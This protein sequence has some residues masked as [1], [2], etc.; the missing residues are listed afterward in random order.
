MSNK[1]RLPAKKLHLTIPSRPG[2]K[3]R[4]SAQTSPSASGKARRQFVAPP[5]TLFKPFLPAK[6]VEQEPLAAVSDTPF[7]PFL[8]AKP[9]EQ[10]STRKEEAIVLKAIAEEDTLVDYAP[11]DISKKRTLSQITEIS[12]PKTPRGDS[13]S[14]E[15]DQQFSE[16]VGAYAAWLV[17][18][19]ARSPQKKD[20]EEKRLYIQEATRTVHLKKRNIN[21]F[22]PFRKEFSAFQTFT[23]KQLVFFLL[24][25]IAWLVGLYFFHLG[26]LTLLVGIVTGTYTVCLFI[27]TLLAARSFWGQVEEHFDNELVDALKSVPWPKYT[28]LC[29]LY[30]EAAIVPQFVEAMKKLDYPE[31]QLQILLLTEEQ[32]RETRKAIRAFHLPRQFEIVVVPNGQPRT[33]PRACNYG[34]LK[35]TGEYVVIYDAEDIPEPRQ[36]KKAV[37]SFANNDVDT[38]CVQAKLNF[39]NSRQNLLTR[40]FAAEYATWF[41]FILPALQSAGFVLPLGGTSNHFRTV[42]LRALGGWDAYNVTEDCDLGLRLKRFKMKTVILDS[43]TLEEANP[44]LKNWLRQRSRW[45]KGYMQTY[46][47]HIRAPLKSLRQEGIKD[48]LSF[49][50]VIGSGVGVLFF[51]PLMWSLLGL[52]MAKRAE[53]VEYYH[54]LFPGPL[55]YLGLLC[56]I[57]GN[58]FYIYLYLLACM[59][60]KDYS[61]VFWSLFIPIYWLL[62]SIAGIYAFFELLVRPHY[63]QKTVHGFHIKG[64]RQQLPQEAAQF[65]KEQTQTIIP[66]FPKTPGHMLLRSI[67]TS[68]QAITT[69]PLPILSGAQR[70]AMAISQRAKTRNLGLLFTL[71]VATIASIGAVI[72][73]YSQHQ[74]LLY[75][76][77][78]SHLDLARKFFDSTN[79]YD[80]T[81][82]GAVWLP[83]PHVLLWPFIWNDF[84]WRSGLAGSCVSLPCYLLSCLFIY[85]SAFA[86]TRDQ[87]ASFLGA[88]AFVLSPDVLYIQAT[89]LSEMVFTATF[90]GA[91]YFFLCFIRE[92][93]T[94]YLVYTAFFTFLATLTRYDG[95]AIVPALILGTF[96]LGIWRKNR[97]SRVIGHTIVYIALGTFGIVLWLAWSKVIFGDP[98][99]FSNGPYSARSQQLDFQHSG[100]LFTYHDLPLSFQYY[101]IDVAQVLGPVVLAF[102]LLGALLC[103]RKY[104]LKKELLFLCVLVVPFVFYVYSLFIGQ[105]IIYVPG[106]EPKTALNEFFNVRYGIAMGPGVA[107]LAA[108]FFAFVKV[109]K[110]G[111][112]QKGK[113]LVQYCLVGLLLGQILLTAQG[114]NVILQDGMMGLSC[115]S[116]SQTDIYLTEHYRGGKVLE[117][118]YVSHITGDVE[119][120]ELRDVIYQGSG[121]LWSNALREPEKYVTWIVVSST[122]QHDLVAQ[123][124]DLTSPSFLAN[125]AVVVQ[126]NVSLYHRKSDPLTRV[127]SI[128]P[129]LLSSYAACNIAAAK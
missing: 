109:Q 66:A 42:A 49:Q 111:L 67:S 124:I 69:L 46:L 96:M 20:L 51:N 3:E 119:G 61:L 14:E 58:F 74:L 129:E 8:P 64:T 125:F 123:N 102:A 85:K 40:W 100:T 10:L 103:I 56:L 95:W 23:R 110:N 35:A 25:A 81:Q 71:S 83:L 50:L 75:G 87:I 11:D 24:L 12:L 72:Y 62:M 37:L 55:L 118:D 113:V 97:F 82:L 38:V 6:P 73:Y 86:L 78:H 2:A 43:T 32:D 41:G 127:R 1:D 59:R 128:S 57:F 91:C 98:L 101:L 33:K 60:R 21:T 94:R 26:M 99:Y 114:G 45:I 16:R 22:A 53:V 17:R 31:E 90:S 70:E 122:S 120:L 27:N 9:V 76:D 121:V 39:Y 5:T 108:C 117:D 54:R 115:R 112:L 79:A 89:P 19:A 18:Q 28:I 126:G 116:L 36:L 13:L 77:A 29:P 52:Y 48:F 84:L 34:L 30:K 7:K 65:V 80:I 4:N 47:T 63:W 15:G 106:L 68:I 92:D 88:L 104:F 93:R 44:D 105:I 107:I